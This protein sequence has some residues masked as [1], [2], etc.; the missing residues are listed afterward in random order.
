MFV[1]SGDWPQL[2]CRPYLRIVWQVVTGIRWAADHIAVFRMV[3]SYLQYVVWMWVFTAF[4][5]KN[6]DH[7]QMLSWDNKWIYRIPKYPRVGFECIFQLRGESLGKNASPKHFSDIGWKKN[8]LNEANTFLESNFLS[9]IYR[10]L[11]DVFL[12]CPWSVD[13]KFLYWISW[14]QLVAQASSER[15]IMH[16]KVVTCSDYQWLSSRPCHRRVWQVEADISWA[17]A[18]DTSGSMF[19]WNKKL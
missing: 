11:D 10:F 8:A 12:T 13:R 2:S 5:E 3:V 16:Q 15:E 9:R 1:A 18:L 4:S 17:A 6:V 14:S 7:F 19:G